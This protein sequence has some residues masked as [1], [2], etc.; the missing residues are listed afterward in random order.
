MASGR[1]VCPQ[2]YCLPCPPS[3]LPSLFQAPNCGSCRQVTVT[4]CACSDEMTWGGGGGEMAPGCI[5]HIISLNH[6]KGAC[7]VQIFCLI[8]LCLANLAWFLAWLHT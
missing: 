4:R 1:A 3:H 7:L 8:S 6:L 5:H 2:A